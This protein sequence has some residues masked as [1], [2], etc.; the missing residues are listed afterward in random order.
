MD[1]REIMQQIKEIGFPISVLAKA[2][3]KDPSTIQKWVTGA[4]KYLKADTELALR[5]EIKKVKN[6]WVNLEI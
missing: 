6:F 2:I 3:N 4:N 5:E 1:T